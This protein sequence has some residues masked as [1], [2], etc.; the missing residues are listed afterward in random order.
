MEIGVAVPSHG[1]FWEKCEPPACEQHDF[2]LRE[3]P[4]P[5]DG[6]GLAFRPYVRIRA[7]LHLDFMALPLTLDSVLSFANQYGAIQRQQQPLARFSIW[8]EEIL[9][10]RTARDLHAGKI[11]PVWEPSQA[12]MN[13]PASLTFAG[14]ARIQRED[15]IKELGRPVIFHESIQ[16]PHKPKDESEWDR[17][18]RLLVASIAQERLR[19]AMNVEIRLSGSPRRGQA[20]TRYMLNVWPNG[21]LP[22]LWYSFILGLEPGTKSKTCRY[23][24]RPFLVGGQ[25]GMRTDALYCSVNCKVNDSRQPNHKRRKTS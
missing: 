2:A 1:H 18:R 9:A 22:F 7:G 21:P 20:R 3:Y 11:K 16:G 6:A 19:E 12:G 8:C 15:Y 5:R 14:F 25:H 17:V 13:L 10:M 23:C 24:K 4:Q